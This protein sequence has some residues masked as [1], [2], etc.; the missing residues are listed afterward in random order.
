MPRKAIAKLSDEV[1]AWEEKH[2]YPVDD[3][4]SAELFNLVEDIGQRNNLAAEHPSEWWNCRAYSSRF[5]SKDI[6]LLASPSKLNQGQTPGKDPTSYTL[7]LGERTEIDPS[8][9]EHLDRACSTVKTVS[10]PQKIS[11]FSI[12]SQ[13]VA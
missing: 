10:G 5:V 9:F 7:D 13:V 8:D 11:S 3:D 12:L 1:E 6:P 4:Q 2:G